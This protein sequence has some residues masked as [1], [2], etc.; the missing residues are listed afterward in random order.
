M[1]GLKKSG[2]ELDRKA[3]ADI[4][5]RDMHTFEQLAEKIKA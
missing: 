2:I 3:L 1:N 5:A 4:A